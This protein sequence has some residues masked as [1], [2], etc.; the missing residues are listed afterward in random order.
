MTQHRLE[1]VYEVLILVESLLAIEDYWRS[2]SQ[3]FFFFL[4]TGG[5]KEKPPATFGFLLRIC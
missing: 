1:K 5:T 2:Y 3:L 4:K